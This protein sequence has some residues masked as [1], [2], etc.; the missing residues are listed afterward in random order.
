VSV[1]SVV[2]GLTVGDRL[3]GTEDMDCE[4]WYG[5]MDRLYGRD[6]V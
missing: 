5:F 6:G 4:Y 1:G 2:V 3:D